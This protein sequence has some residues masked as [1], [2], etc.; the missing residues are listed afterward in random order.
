[1]FSRPLPS[2]PNPLGQLIDHP[3]TL[4]LCGCR[5]VEVGAVHDLFDVR[6]S[7]DRAGKHANLFVNV[8]LHGESC[9]QRFQNRLRVDVHTRTGFKAIRY[10]PHNDGTD[11]GNHPG[12]CQ[13]DPTATPHR[14][15][16]YQEL[17]KYLF[18]QSH[19]VICANRI[20]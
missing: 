3:V 4:D 19:S 5:H 14:A 18:H 6:S 7:D 8:G 15:A 9:H 10:L 16:D 2:E 11:D 13:S 17:P 20:C 1:M 12:G